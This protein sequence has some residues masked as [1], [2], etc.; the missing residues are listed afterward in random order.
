[1]SEAAYHIGKNGP[2]KCP[3]TIQCRL[4]NLDGS[5]Q[6]HGNSAR[7]AQLLYELNNEE[8]LVPKRDNSLTNA[9]LSQGGETVLEFSRAMRASNELRDNRSAYTDEEY[10]EVLKLVKQRELKARSEFNKVCADYPYLDD[11]EPDYV[12]RSTM[13]TPW[14]PFVA[15]DETRYGLG[16]DSM[17][18][19]ISETQAQLYEISE[20]WA[21]RLTTNEVV[22]LHKYSVDSLSYA[23]MV[24]GSRRRD[25]FY[26]K[27][28]E[29]ALAKAPQVE[30]PVRV[31]G[32][33]SYSRA[34]DV[35]DQ[36]ESGTL[37]LTRIQ[38][39][40]LNPSIAAEFMA[41][42]QGVMTEFETKTVPSLAAFSYHHDELEVIVPPGAYMVQETHE[43]ISYVGAKKETL[44][45]QTYVYKRI[46]RE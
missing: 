23:K 14:T 21:K 32:G 4:S 31:Y 45:N 28:L 39:T 43:N 7:D 44:S 12:P 18:V 24:D 33:I 25:H 11:P 40:S 13:P 34:N 6:E 27:S 2:E 8:F 22:A 1:M 36:S 5:A 30:T 3:A 26:L 37:T 9:G 35:Q 19:P 16:H 20:E 29:S 42:P 46:E 41:M 17:G 15:G 10:K 38:S